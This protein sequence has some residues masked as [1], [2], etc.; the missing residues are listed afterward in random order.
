MNEHHPID[1]LF[2]EAISEIE[3]PPSDKVWSSLDKKLEQKNHAA[4][5]S[6]YLFASAAVAGSLLVAAYYFLSDKNTPSSLTEKHAVQKPV[7]TQQTVVTTAQAS[8]PGKKQAA[9]QHTITSAKKV[10]ETTSATA[11][12]EAKASERTA[13]VA[14]PAKEQAAKNEISTVA[15]TKETP[16]KKEAS[17]KDIKLVPSYPAEQSQPHA[18]ANQPTK[19]VVKNDPAEVPAKNE[20]AAAPAT[21]ENVIYVPNAFTPNG[22]GLNDVFLPK[23]AEEPK[24]YKLY[25]FEPSGAMIFY[26]DD[27]SKGWDG[28][29]THN[30][31]ETTK[32]GLYMWKIEVKNSKGEKE[33]RMGYVNLLR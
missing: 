26:S 22:D 16:A 8:E 1:E 14:E 12:S 15:I 9:P 21:S 33:V 17:D 23:A 2:R 5:R 31:I 18:A 24:E 11:Q 20:T 19:P 25:I 7:A 6:K 13:T 3:L 4:K 32:E 27:F 28:K 30:G 10:K 29:V